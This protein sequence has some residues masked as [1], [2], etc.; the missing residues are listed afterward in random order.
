M[1]RST[2][3]MVESTISELTRIL[4]HFNQFGRHI[5]H[6]LKISEKFR[7]SQ[8]TSGPSELTP[9]SATLERPSVISE[10]PSA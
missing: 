5:S 3:R 10:R 7:K 4:Y 2:S 8:V 9:D 1:P 6:D